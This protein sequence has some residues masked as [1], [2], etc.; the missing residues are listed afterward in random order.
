MRYCLC[1]TTPEKPKYAAMPVKSWFFICC[2]FVAVTSHAQKPV[3]DPIPIDSTI[4]DYDALFNELEAFIDSIT[5]PRNFIMFNVGVSSGYY[6][7]ENKSSYYLETSRKLTLAPSLSYFDKSGF[8]IS[9]EASIMSDSTQWNPYQYS[10]TGSYDYIR[11]RKFMAGAS[12]THF[13][14]KDNLAF[15]TSPLQNEAYAYFTYRHF[16]LKPTVA[17][18]YGWG[19]RSAYDEREGYINSIQLADRG[20]VRVNTQETVNDFN[21]VTSVRHDFYW[22]NVFSKKDYIKLTPVVVFTSGTHQFGFNQTSNSYI[23]LRRTGVNVLYNTENV[24][25]DNNLYF[26]PISLAGFLKADYTIGK[27]FVQP[28][29]IFDYYYPTNQNNFTTTFV[30]N[31]GVVF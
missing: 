11:N 6:N 30:L 29:V 15:Y 4:T 24:S 26:Q 8:G 13:F 27:V 31:A 21:L 23:T 16:W 5:A 3:K 7:F 22:L 9:A 10:L 18:S 12:L 14:T 25:L 2:V 28:Q 19:S 1:E 20:F 17:V